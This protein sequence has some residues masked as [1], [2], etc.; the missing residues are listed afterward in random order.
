MKLTETYI[1]FPLPSVSAE[2]G[3]TA[4]IF[5]IHTNKGNKKIANSM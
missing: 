3:N 4:I 2:I 1:S 5:I